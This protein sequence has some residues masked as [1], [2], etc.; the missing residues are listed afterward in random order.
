MW[1]AATLSR[2][3][4]FR[5]SVCIALV[6]VANQVFAERVTLGQALALADSAH[7]LLH[8]GV[9]QVDAARAGVTTATAYPNPDGSIVAGRQTGQPAGSPTNVV[10]MY[11]FSQP[12]ELGALR[13]ARIQLA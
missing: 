5:S 4:M 1:P 10:P 9:A 12:L 3:R 2:R 13:P 6:L 8:A 11:V 7:P